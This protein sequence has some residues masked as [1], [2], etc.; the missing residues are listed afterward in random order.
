MKT[1]DINNSMDIIDSRDVIARFE[2]LESERADLETDIE[3]AQDDLDNET[4]ADETD[5]LQTILNDAKAALK[6]WDD[7]NGDELKSL[8]DLADQGESYASDW[9]YGATLI[10]ESYFETYARELVEDIGDLPKELPPYIENN[11]DW[12]G[13]ADELKADYTSVDFDGETYLIR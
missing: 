1:A 2:E 7:D 11:I 4:N 5:A 13:V 8:K 10:R 9:Q 3:T 6:S 12:E